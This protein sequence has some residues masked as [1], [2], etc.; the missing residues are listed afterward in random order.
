MKTFRPVAS[1]ALCPQLITPYGRRPPL[2]SAVT[3]RQP[4]GNILK[5]I[6]GWKVVRKGRG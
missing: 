2:Q 3:I 1:T 6:E 4:P 5:E